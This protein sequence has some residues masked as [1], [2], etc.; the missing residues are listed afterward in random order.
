MSTLPISSAA[1][2]STSNVAS[3]PDSHDSSQDSLTNQNNSKEMDTSVDKDNSKHNPVVQYE[4]V[5]IWSCLPTAKPEL[6]SKLR[7]EL[8]LIVLE[9]S[10]RQTLISWSCTCRYYYDRASDVLWKSLYLRPKEVLQFSVHRRLDKRM[11]ARG[12][13]RDSNRI[14]FFL[15]E[16]AFRGRLSGG[17]AE[18]TPPAKAPRHRVRQLRVNFLGPDPKRANWASFPYSANSL[19][20]EPDV[21]RLFGLM[22]NLRAFSFDGM[23]HPA[24]FHTIA[25]PRKLHTLKLRASVKKLQHLD[26]DRNVGGAGGA[27]TW[28][29]ILQ[30]RSL[31]N[32]T[33]LRKLTV[34]RLVPDEAEGLAEAV[35]N[36]HLSHLSVFAAPPAVAGDQDFEISFRGKVHDESPILTFLRWIQ[37][38]GVHNGTAVGPGAGCLPLTLQVLGL[39]DHYRAWQPGNGDLLLHTVNPCR[40]LVK[41]ELCVKAVRP[42]E[43]FLQHA[44][45]PFLDCLCLEGCRHS[46]TYADWTKLGSYE[47]DVAYNEPPSQLALNLGR[48]LRKHRQTLKFLTFTHTCTSYL[49]PTGE[50]FA[51]RFTIQDLSGLWEMKRR[52][53]LTSREMYQR[54]SAKGT[55]TNYCHRSG[56][57]YSQDDQA[58]SEWYFDPH[59]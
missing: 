51:L 43:N 16:D 38:Q 10:D 32:L 58:T 27:Q 49:D 20:I 8:I 44:E 6:W 34:G 26:Y 15:K 21:S 25:F 24:T 47:N 4:N 50:T 3:T 9:N 59:R 45:L 28:N 57:C 7:P 1:H 33:S 39:K 23:L 48:F 37:Q 2:L 29:Q 14:M 54:N 18:W 41:L 22:P 5:P 53:D 12:I 13:K 35:V 42:L 11:V 55:W 36:L 46:L 17:L 52:H 40:S 56:F 30:F 19:W 31:S